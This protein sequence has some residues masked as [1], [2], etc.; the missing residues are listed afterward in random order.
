MEL[1][2]LDGNTA[3]IPTEVAWRGSAVLGAVDGA[4]A[5]PRPAMLFR[6]GAM[7]ARGGPAPPR[8]CQLRSSRI[9][10][11]AVSR[12][13][14]CRYSTTA[15]AAPRAGAPAASSDGSPS[16]AQRAL[17]WLFTGGAV[18]A[19]CGL[20]N[21]LF[22]CPVFCQLAVELAQRDPRVAAAAGGAVSAKWWGYAWSGTTFH[23]RAAV[24]IPLTVAGGASGTNW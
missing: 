2:R 20:A 4:C 10:V 5:A 22:D 24:T 16:I 9:H 21:H 6:R 18:V 12:P 11:Q 17:G 7:A 8:C 14:I 19:A 23:N 15:A 1:P 13:R 3:H